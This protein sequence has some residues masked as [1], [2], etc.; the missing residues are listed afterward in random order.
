MQGA[1]EFNLSIEDRSEHQNSSATRTKENY[2]DY[3]RALVTTRV[4]RSFAPAFPQ[5]RAASLI[6]SRNETSPVD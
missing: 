6:S 4:A 2:S 5:R 3:S 1:L